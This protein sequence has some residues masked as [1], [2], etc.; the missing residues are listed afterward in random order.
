MRN[1]EQDLEIGREL[2]NYRDFAKKEKELAKPDIDTLVEKI[3]EQLG[4]AYDEAT[5][6]F[7]RE[8]LNAET[9]VK[10]QFDEERKEFKEAKEM[11]QNRISSRILEMLGPVGE[12]E[13][14]QDEIKLYNIGTVKWATE[15][16]PYIDL[17][18]IDKAELFSE[19]LEMDRPDLLQINEKAYLEFDAQFAKEHGSHLAGVKESFSIKTSIRTAK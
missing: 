7:I 8:I 12:N 1:Y 2:Q 13:S 4:M 10:K 6:Q 16:K 9:E 15:R 19:I 18:D 5:H 14:F 17:E 11:S 3:K